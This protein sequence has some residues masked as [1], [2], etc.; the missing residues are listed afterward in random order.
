MLPLTRAPASLR[1]RLCSSPVQLEATQDAI[2]RCVEVS[3]VV[4]FWIV[5]SAVA[6]VGGYLNPQPVQQVAVVQG[7]AAGPPAE[8][9]ADAGRVGGAV[10]LEP[11]V[12]AGGIFAQ[13]FGF[14]QVRVCLSLDSLPFVGGSAL[15]IGVLKPHS[16]GPTSL[17]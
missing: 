9:G 13:M 5:L 11:Q 2:S 7:A 16:T 1:R 14:S 3:F 12:P 6:A 10:V 8:S 17:H 15:H 4:G